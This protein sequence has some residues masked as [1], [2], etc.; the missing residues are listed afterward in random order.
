MPITQDELVR[1]FGLAVE[2]RNAALFVGAGLSTDAGIPGWG[3]LLQN[4]RMRADVPSSLNDMPLVAQY[5]V[6]ALP[7]G[8]A[9]LEAAILDSIVNAN[10]APS[11]GH[12]TIARMPL[13]EIWTTNYD[14]LLETAMPDARLVVAEEDLLDRRTHS[15]R[16]LIKMHGSVNAAGSG[17]SRAPVIT[18]GDYEGYQN[19]NPRMWSALQ[20]TYLTRSTLFLGFSFSDPNVDIL[21]RLSRTLPH[22]SEGEHFTVLRRPTGGDKEKLHDHQVRDLEGSGVAVCEVQEYDELI[23]ILQALE[24]RTRERCL[25][26]SGNFDEKDARTK[27][28][29]RRVGSGLASSKLSIV[30]LA[31]AAGTE[32]SFALGE[33]LMAI[34]AYEPGR[35]Q[36]YFREKKDAAAP[37]MHKR[38][39][40]AIYSAL[41]QVD[42]RRSVIGK[43]RAALVINGG[44]GTKVEIQMCLDASLPVVPLAAAGGAA[45]VW[46]SA[47]DPQAANLPTDA[48]AQRDWNLLNSNDVDIA[49]QAARRLIDRATYLDDPGAVG[50]S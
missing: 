1:Q 17:W 27:L 24:R 28:I 37:I 6:T 38:I 34:D 49:I 26:V 25:F 46:W 22:S 2:S 12:E 13:E 19:D 29:A 18:R 39:G 5:I 4:L 44:I 41:E 31:G 9:T 40:T 50:G 36:Y 11:S 23:P 43:A 21:L 35:L 3:G 33:A 15:S 47:N 10:S 48:M 14:R 45:K 8:R 42:L 30:S 20:A 7:G 32:L 16:R